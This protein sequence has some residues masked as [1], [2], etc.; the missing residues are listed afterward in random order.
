MSPRVVP[1]LDGPSRELLEANPIVQIQEAQW[2]LLPELWKACFLQ[3]AEV[4]VSRV[5]GEPGEPEARGA[6]RIRIAECV[7]ARALAPH[8]PLRVCLGRRPVCGEILKTMWG[9]FLVV[10]PTFGTGVSLAFLLLFLLILFLFLFYL[11]Y[12][13]FLSSQIYFFF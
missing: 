1:P 9:T 4:A 10:P 13:L 8:L 11:F 6:R 5:P 7:L 3:A 12:F 2:G